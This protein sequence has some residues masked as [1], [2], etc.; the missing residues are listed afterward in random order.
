M[1]VDATAPGAGYLRRI[2]S[3]GAQPF[4]YRRRIRALLGLPER[5]GP[6]MNFP[7]LTAPVSGFHDIDFGAESGVSAESGRIA[8]VVAPDAPRNP[9]PIGRVSAQSAWSLA[10]N[11]PDISAHVVQTA[12]RQNEGE[13]ERPEAAIKSSPSGRVHQI[14]IP[15]VRSGM[16]PKPVQST[17]R[18]HSRAMVESGSADAPPNTRHTETLTQSPKNY[19]A[20]A[21]SAPSLNRVQERVS[22]ETHVSNTPDKPG[23]E[24][25]PAFVP[26]PP[27]QSQPGTLASRERV[28]QRRGTGAPQDPQKAEST[29][30][31][32][33]R[34][35]TLSAHPHSPGHAAEDR[36]I[37]KWG[38]PSA[39]PQKLIRMSDKPK[40]SRGDTP[41][42]SDDWPL[43]ATE[44]SPAA[45]PA[46]VAAPPVQAAPMIESPSAAFWER[47]Y[48]NRLRLRM[49]R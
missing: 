11:A 24:S 3:G 28:S 34:S 9:S 7:V 47:R 31:A 41:S 27:L 17:G 30:A 19:T 33:R 37:A 39:T 8:P 45:P 43:R 44:A 32:P 22:A 48:L 14:V 49:R 35:L 25:C 12:P 4:L 6:R 5:G 21:G 13:E 38:E 18:S 16:K 23:E 42:S 29:G 10:E 20:P 26:E 2:V 40:S 15:G 36:E 1:P 46:P